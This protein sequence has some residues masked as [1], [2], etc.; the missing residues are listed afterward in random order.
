MIILPYVCSTCLFTELWTFVRFH[1]QNESVNPIQLEVQYLWFISD[2]LKKT[3]SRNQL[4][5]YREKSGILVITVILIYMLL[6]VNNRTDFSM[7]D[8]CDG[9]V[10]KL[11]LRVSC[12]KATMNQE[13]EVNLSFFLILSFLFHAAV[14]VVFPNQM[15]RISLLNRSRRKLLVLEPLS[16]SRW[17][18]HKTKRNQFKE[19]PLN[20]QRL[21]K[22]I[23][24]WQSYELTKLIEISLTHL[25]E[26]R[27]QGPPWI[28]LS[29]SSCF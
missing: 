15:R 5:V 19:I 4:C 16:F 28:S 3:F 12:T 24:K 9:G 11:L 26:I 25:T 6:T 13:N 21:A 29:V 22:E 10:K 7:K 23:A 20:Q 1:C 27:R 8:P 14:G 17:C 18:L 2:Q